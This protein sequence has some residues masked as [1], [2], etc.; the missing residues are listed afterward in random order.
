MANH[1]RER[2]IEEAMKQKM[3]TNILKDENLKLK[4]RIHILEAELQKK[5]KLMEEM[6]QDSFQANSAKHKAGESHLLL[7]LKKKIREVQF[8]V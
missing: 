5:V 1:D 8:E 2:I 7:N 6:L 3:A 4:T